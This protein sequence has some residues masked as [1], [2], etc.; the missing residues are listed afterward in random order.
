MF[1]R[2]KNEGVFRCEGEDGVGYKVK[3]GAVEEVDED[4]GD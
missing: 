2:N 1:L 4:E 3:A